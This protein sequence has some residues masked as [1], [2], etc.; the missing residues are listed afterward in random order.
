MLVVAPTSLAPAMIGR[1][2]IWLINAILT[3]LSTFAIL[4]T[5]F[6][7]PLRMPEALFAPLIVAV[8]CA[9]AYGFSLFVGSF[10]IRIPSTRNIASNLAT[11]MLTAFCGVAVPVTFWPGWIQTVA[12]ILPVTHGLQSMRLLLSGGSPTA[13]I[14]GVLLEAA[15]GLGWLTLAILTMDRMADRGRRDGSIEFV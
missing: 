11:T 1:T 4:V 14:A 6:R 5:L 8:V 2:S 9:S 7:F 10:V 15:V 13:I 3:S 12:A